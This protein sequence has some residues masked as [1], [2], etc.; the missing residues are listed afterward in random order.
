[1]SAATYLFRRVPK[2][3]SQAIRPQGSN[4]A[5]D[6]QRAIFQH[7]NFQRVVMRAASDYGDASI[8]FPEAEHFPDSC[9]IEDTCVS[10]RPG[11]AVAT[12]PAAPSRRGESGLIRSFLDAAV[13]NGELEQVY[14]L[15]GSEKC[16][17]GDVL[18]IEDSVFIGASQRTNS[19]AHARW[20][21]I[22][23]LHGMKCVS[24]PVTDSLH[25]KSFVTWLHHDVGLVAQKSKEGFIAAKII[26]D[27]L[28]YNF[29]AVNFISHGANMLRVHKTIIHEPG[30]AFRRWRRLH[31][32]LSFVECNMSEL[33][34]AGGALTCGVVALKMAK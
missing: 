7:E 13:L 9:F 6:V 31:K 12:M 25:L 4:V 19:N 26:S 32:D 14:H 33:N 8:T 3:F 22:C 16:D 23:N 28:D 17:G 5:I 30:L 15:Q 27:T 10:L 18:V 2:S 24:I 34:K 29:Q 21:Q 20:N 1:M 11:I